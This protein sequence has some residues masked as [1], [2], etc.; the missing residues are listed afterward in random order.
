MAGVQVYREAGGRLSRQGVGVYAQA[1]MAARPGLP[2]EEEGRLGD[3]ALR[4]NFVERV[5]AYRRWLALRREGF[6]RAKLFAFHRAHTLTL[7][8]HGGQPPEALG[9]LVATASQR[10]L[11]ELAA[12]YLRE[13]MAA[14]KRPATRTSHTRVLTRLAGYLKRE[15]GAEDRERLAQTIAGYRQGSVPLI[16]PINLLRQHCLKH[17]HP[18]AVGQVYLEPHPAE[19]VLRSWL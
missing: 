7:M 8:A 14:L 2:I 16:V 1:L 18:D 5:F 19:A 17:P 12:V 3:A 6:S 11:E 15:L 4:E 10:P 9:R 13:F